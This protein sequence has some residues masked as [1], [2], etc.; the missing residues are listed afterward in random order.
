[1]RSYACSS[2]SPSAVYNVS[3]FWWGSVIVATQCIG[4]GMSFYPMVLFWLKL[5][6]KDSLSICCSRLGLIIFLHE[7]I[8]SVPSSST[9]SCPLFSNLPGIP[10]LILIL[11]SRFLT[12]AVVIG[13]YVKK[14]NFS[15]DRRT[16]QDN[17]IIDKD[18]TA[19]L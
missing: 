1:M 8:L 15:L 4:G 14:K 18:P 11:F 2:S 13:Y 17:F 9:T 5:L 7:Y 12:E 10:F 3:L 19:I 6:A 16:F